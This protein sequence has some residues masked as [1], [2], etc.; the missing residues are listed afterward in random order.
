MTTNGKK[1]S[2]QEMKQLEL[3]LLTKFAEVC[4][5]NHL[6]YGL[7]GG[8][9]LGAIRHKGFIPWDDDI[10]IIM[11][12]PD[13]RKLIE[14][15]QA[16][17]GERYTLRAHYLQQDY[18]YPYAKA[19]DNRTTLVGLAT[20]NGDMGVCIDI[21]PADGLPADPAESE[22]HIQKILHY[23]R[24]RAFST[25]TNLRGRTI[26]HSVGK[27]PVVAFTKLL[28][29][30]YWLK[31]I[32][33]LATSYDFEQSQ[34]VGVVVADSYGS[35][36]RIDKPSF[37]A[38]VNVEFEGRQFKAPVGYEQ[39]LKNI[40]GDYMKL[41]PEN[42]RVTAHTFEAYWRDGEGETGE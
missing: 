20:M 23:H 1:I 32:E 41:P 17:L 38:Y 11:P 4:E 3:T 21:F 40:Y 42:K 36:E 15:G 33:D 16:A 19:T 12:R 31:K 29:T 24:M 34:Y 35:R 27:A 10:D 26:L 28:G 7:A 14:L 9:M 30:A 13:Y 37:S 25:L 6:R 2:L 8:T 5:E 39:Y 18:T 22:Q